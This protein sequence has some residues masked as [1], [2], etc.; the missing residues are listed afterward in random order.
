VGEQ[1]VLT[2]VTVGELAQW[3]KLRHWGPGNR[4]MSG[5]WLAG[6]LVIPGGKAMA[7][8]WAVCQSRPSSAGGLARSPAPGLL[9]G[10]QLPLAAFDLKDFKDFARAPRVGL[11]EP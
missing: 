1:S 10:C 3:T 4:A 2:F 8:V 7:A 5:S 9:P 6:K 11:L